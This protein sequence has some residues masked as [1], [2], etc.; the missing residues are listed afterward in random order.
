MGQTRD[1]SLIGKNPM[2]FTYELNLD[3]I[4]FELHAQI[5]IRM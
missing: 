1:L 2:T 5:Q 3:I 4:P